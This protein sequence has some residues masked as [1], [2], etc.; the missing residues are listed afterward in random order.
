MPKKLAAVATTT[1]LTLMII[2]RTM[3]TMTTFTQDRYPV[4]APHHCAPLHLLRQEKTILIPWTSM[5]TRTSV[6][7]V[8]TNLITTLYHP[9]T[10]LRR[11]LQSLH[12]LSHGQ[13]PPREKLLRITLTT[14]Q[15]LIA[16]R[17]VSKNPASNSKMLIYC[18]TSRIAH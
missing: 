3:M 8:M 15:R 12:G 13:Q 14:S 2:I 7:V 11:R 17:L 16:T 9:P 10:T 1:I 4:P 18:S 6:R 5:E